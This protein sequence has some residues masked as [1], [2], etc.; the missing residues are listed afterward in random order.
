MLGTSFGRG[1]W[2]I[3]FWTFSW[4][5]LGKGLGIPGSWDLFGYPF[6]GCL[7]DIFVLGNRRGTFSGIFLE[8]VRDT[9]LSTSV[10]N[11]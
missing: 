10:I 11:E 3:L 4:D 8:H 2:N 5:K 7:W 6:G 1:V 9:F